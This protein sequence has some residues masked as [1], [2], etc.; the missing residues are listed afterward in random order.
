LLLSAGATATIVDE[1]AVGGD[2]HMHPIAPMLCR[3]CA[4]RHHSIFW[5]VLIA[6]AGQHASAATIVNAPNPA[7]LTDLQTLI[8]AAAPDTIIKI[9]PQE[10]DFGPGF[11]KLNTWGV[12]LQ[13]AGPGETVFKSSQ[14]IPDTV[15]GVSSCYSSGEGRALLVMCGLPTKPSP[16]T[17]PTIIENITFKNSAAGDAILTS[18]PD[19]GIGRSATCLVES[20]A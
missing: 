5:V 4:A 8:T 6:F 11:L 12:S 16:F 9:P 7:T 15:N 13:G 14:N 17:T 2:M 19:K 18:G 20:A 10:I 1:G 3:M